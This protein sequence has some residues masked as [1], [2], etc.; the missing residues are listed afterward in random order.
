MKN[1]ISIAGL[2]GV[3]SAILLLAPI[4]VCR[5]DENKADDETPAS[6][7]DDRVVDDDEPK[8]A[9]DVKPV[10]L[11]TVSELPWNKKSMPPISLRSRPTDPRQLLVNIDDSEFESF[12]DGQDLDGNHQ[13]LIKILYRLPRFG[14]GNI[15]RLARRDE[16]SAIGEDSSEH[17]IQIHLLKG[18]VIRVTR[19][20]L[21]PEVARIFDFDHFFQVHMQADN[22]ETP[23]LINAR[24][25]PEA[26]KAK[27]DTPLNEPASAYGLF[28]QV[29]EQTDSAGPLIFAAHYIAWFPESV[30][31][32]L[33]VNSE[34][35]YLAG[36]GVDVGQFDHVK[37]RNRKT[38]GAG[39]YEG[40]YQTLAACEK[41]NES[42]VPAANVSRFDLAKLLTQP[43]TKHG[44]VMVVNANARR[45]NTVRVESQDV[46]DRFGFDHYYQIDGFVDLGDQSIRVGKEQGDKSGPVYTNK[47]P[48][49][50][51]VRE[52]PDD[53]RKIHEQAVAD[54]T[55][56]QALNERIRITGVFFKLWAYRSEFIS[57]FDGSQRQLSPMFIAYS[58][59]L[60]QFQ[61]ASN[62]YVGVA[63][64][65]GFLV[66]LAG[67]WIGVMVIGRSDKKFEREVMNKRYEVSQGESLNDM[68][69]ET[70]D[71]P[72][73]SGLHEATE[74][75]NASENTDDNS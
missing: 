34:L 2:F 44:S 4:K 35:V 20:N 47:F 10:P 28:L 63:V 72:D 50:I 57:S 41:I 43:E 21:V 25:I 66:L 58:P 13:A 49:T 42:D 5:A 3:V 52:L 55:L 36:L 40:F 29:G 37:K 70:V 60:T 19:Q 30:D 61:K 45:I 54:P 15:E 65:V 27:L 18:R 12:F 71:G 9:N 38:L 48:V 17:R 51:C 56:G 31:E 14:Q 67:L 74:K 22:F 24:E 68:D 26:W 6:S 8:N 11:G 64:G 73:F 62:P 46:Q 33:G 39:D 69:I 53:L 32:E 16:L 7:A 23:V 1:W 75:R 59:K